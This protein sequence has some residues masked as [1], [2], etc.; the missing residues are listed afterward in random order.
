MGIDLEERGTNNQLCPRDRFTS[1]QTCRRC[2]F[3]HPMNPLTIG[4]LHAPCRITDASD[5]SLPNI[6]L[7]V[8]KDVV[9]KLERNAEN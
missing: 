9:K 4:A 5:H 8:L 3:L 7:A 6:K 2:N 1:I